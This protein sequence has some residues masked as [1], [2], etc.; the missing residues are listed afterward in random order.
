ML[1]FAEQTGSGAVMLVWSFPPHR[2]V[3]LSIY[4]YVLVTIVGE[5]EIENNTSTISIKV[6]PT[7]FVTTIL[8]SST[9]TSSTSER[10]KK[11]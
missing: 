6:I 11:K 9:T 3:S 2:Q 7:I 10:N 4:C 1:N 8:T 5:W